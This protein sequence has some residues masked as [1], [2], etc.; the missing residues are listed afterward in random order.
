MAAHTV[1]NLNT[2]TVSVISHKLQVHLCLQTKNKSK[3]TGIIT[4]VLMICQRKIYDLIPTQDN[5]QNNYEGMIYT[6]HLVPARIPQLQQK[7]DDSQ[8]GGEGGSLQG[9]VQEERQGHVAVSKGN[10]C[11]A[12]PTHSWCKVNSSL[13]IVLSLQCCLRAPLKYRCLCHIEGTQQVL[14]WLSME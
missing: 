10:S 9:Q 8:H 14:F 2:K 5:N 3:F 4:L 1:V 7:S 6:S 12:T 11:H 13:I